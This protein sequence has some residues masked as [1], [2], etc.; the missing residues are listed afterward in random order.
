MKKIVLIAVVLGLAVGTGLAQQPGGA[1]DAKDARKVAGAET[2]QK[3]IAAMRA[4]AKAFLDQYCKDLAALEIK[5]NLAAWTAANTG[6]KEDFAVVAEANLAL[7]KFHSSRESY[8]KIL[9][10]LKS[11]DQLDPLDA[12]A[13]E[14]AELDFKGNQ[15]PA[16][17]LKQMVDLSTEIEQTFKTFRA[18]IDG[19]KLSNN[20]LLEMIR[21]ETDSSLRRTYWEALKQV[22]SA[23]APKLI[24]LAKLRNRA[25][26]QLGYPNYW[27]MRIRLQEHE[28]AQLLAIFAELEQLTDEPFRKMK[29]NMD[30]RAVAPRSRSSPRR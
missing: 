7:R 15:L 9:D 23:V 13:L 3:E 14:V 26:R 27:D 28:P 8:E 12:R 21:K 18:E 5:A 1:A 17:M 2:A 25:A 4:E 20:D 19:K 30:A 11:K 16:D 10:L 29:G 22:G 6:K 24:E